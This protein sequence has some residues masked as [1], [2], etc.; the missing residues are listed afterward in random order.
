MDL[1]DFL[2]NLESQSESEGEKSEITMAIDGDDDMDQ[3]RLTEKH[4][5]GE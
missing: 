4:Q 1:G 2:T 3:R 5:E